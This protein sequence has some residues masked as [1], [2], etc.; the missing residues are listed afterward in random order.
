MN[1]L[2]AWETIESLYERHG[3]NRCPRKE[4]N[5]VCLV[6][7]IGRTFGGKVGWTELQN[8]PVMKRL[9]NN[10]GCDH[11]NDAI[12]Y[13][14]R[15]NRE[16]VLALIAQCRSECAAEQARTETREEALV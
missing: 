11:V 2:T 1:E 5:E 10:L 6:S 15:H 8:H 12:R 7:A 13:N 9:R 16:E 3:V 14:D 4:E